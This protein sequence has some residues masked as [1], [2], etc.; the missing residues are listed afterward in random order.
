MRRVQMP[1]KTFKQ[2]QVHREAAGERSPG[3]QKWGATGRKRWALC[4]TAGADV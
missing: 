1:P 2:K 3:R 4:N